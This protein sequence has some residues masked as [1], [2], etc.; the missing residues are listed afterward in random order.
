MNAENKERLIEKLETGI[1]GFDL[2][3][4]GGLP[5]DR[6]TLLA[7]TAGSGKTVFGVQF[8]AE[9]I[10]QAGENAVF[11]TFEEQPEDI[12]KNM[13]SL[14]WDISQWED[15][16]KWAFVDAS[17]Q[18]GREIIL[19][20]EYDFGALIARIENAV[21][22]VAAKRLTIDS[23]S[24]IFTQFQDASIVRNELFRVATALKNLEM[25]AIIT[26]ERTQEYGEISRYGV[27]EFVADNVVIF[28]NVL[29]EEK[30]RRTLEILK[31]R[32]TSHQKGEFPFTISPDT[33]VNVIPLSAMELKQKSSNIRIKAGNAELDRGLRGWVLPRFHHP[34]IRSYWK[35]QDPLW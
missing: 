18:P 24:G 30:R 27:E 1:S 35:R 2:V 29:Q 19:S 7:G 17:P 16:G 28:R 26:A 15:E 33:G 10:K 11:V 31:F 32:G 21:K 9:G 22:K 5:K 25:T 12:R 20:G 23:V 8:L 13:R 4:N 34:D 6:T 3:A 14:G